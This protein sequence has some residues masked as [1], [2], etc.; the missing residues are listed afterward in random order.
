MK[1]R[2]VL[3][4]L[5][6]LTTMVLVSTSFS[7]QIIRI[8]SGEW[9][10]YQSEKLEHYG[11]ASRIVTEAFALEDIAVVYDFMPWKRSMEMSK[12]GK[13]DATFLWKVTDERKPYFNASMPIIE[14]QD[15]FFHLKSTEFDW[16]QIEDLKDIKIGATLGYE[17]GDAFQKAEKKG[18][19]QVER[20]ADDET[21]FKKLLGKRMPVFVCS[22]TVGYTLLNKMYN[23]ETVALFTNHPKPIKETTYHLLFS[24]AV[25]ENE[26]R[27]IKFNAGLKKLKENGKIDQYVE[28]SRKN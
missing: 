25:P 21:S 22:I 4:T 20:A 13:W 28:E 12:R 3:I 8:A 15:V 24:K 5:S 17:Y 11:F 1:K 18:I 14:D 2:I 19:I 6:L 9:P 16:N 26:D 27:L 10:P 23:K 7:E